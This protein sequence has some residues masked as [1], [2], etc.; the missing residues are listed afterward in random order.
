MSRADKERAIYINK[1]NL[2]MES[3]LGKYPDLKEKYQVKERLGKQIEDE[4]AMRSV[5]EEDSGDS[6]NLDEGEAGPLS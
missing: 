3:L 1:L 2:I 4:L 6:E 5:M